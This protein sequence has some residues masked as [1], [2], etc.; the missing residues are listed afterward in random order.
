MSVRKKLIVVGDGNCGKTCLLTVFA[1]DQFSEEYLPTVFEAD[2]VN[3]TLDD[4]NTVMLILLDT[5]GQEEYDRLRPIQYPGTDVVLICFSVVWPDSFD[6]V[7]EKWIPEVRHFC[8]KIPIVLVGTKNDLRSDS[9]VLEQLQKL[10]KKPVTTEA[11]EALAKQMRAV[12][13]VECSAKTKFNVSKVFVT[14][15]NAAINYRPRKRVFNCTSF[16]N[17]TDKWIP[18]VRHFCP[19]VPVVLVG[20][21]NDLRSDSSA[22]EKLDRLSPVLTE[23][24]EAMAKKMKAVAYIK[25]SSKTRCGINSV[26]VTAARAALNPRSKKTF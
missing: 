1:K 17:V 19:N 20:T 11:A 13:Y 2:I 8:P 22:F 18:E 9:S 23:V 21:K 16:D 25:C 24:A 12:A 7:T 26:F 6:N 15:A 10:D 14:A 3:M 5:S 4:C